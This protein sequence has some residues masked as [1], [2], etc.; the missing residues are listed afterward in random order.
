MSVPSHSLGITRYQLFC[1]LAASLS[2]LNYGWNYGVVN[3]PGDII[4]KCDAGPQYFTNKFPSCMPTSDTIWGL[5][6]G[7]FP[8]GALLGAISCTHFANAYGRRAVLIYSNIIS[9]VAAAILG[10]ALNIPMLITARFL[11]GIAQ[12]CANGTYSNYVAEITTP[13]ARNTLGTVI[14]LS[15]CMGTMLSQLVSLGLV[16][17][18]LWRVLFATTGMIS[19]VSI[20]LLTKCVE[21]PKWLISKQRIYEAQNNLQ[22]LR[23][24]A[25]C[26]VEFA[27]LV[28]TVHAEMGP[29][30]YTATVPDLLRGRTPNNLRHQLLLAVL[31]MSFQQLSGIGGVSFY[32]T[33]LF[34]SIASAPSA[35]YTSKPQLAQILTAVVSTVG[36]VA[37]LVGAIMAGY[38]G[39]RSLL[40]FSHGAMAVSSLLIAVGSVKGYNLLAITMVFIFYCV[41]IVGAGSL[42]WIFPGEMTPIYAVSA[43]VAVSGSIAY[44]CVFVV[45]IVFPLLMNAWNGY[46][47]LLFAAINF[48]ATVLFFFLLPETKDKQVSEMIRIHSVGIHNVMKRK[49]RQEN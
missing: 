24:S 30:S 26:T 27:T 10:T 39:R 35:E 15:I 2:S 37:A 21:S 46:T 1:V 28:E 36:T 14:Q 4:T 40:L 6:I 12:G 49:Y 22:R 38:F 19:I 20:W 13:R 11:V 18:P 48:I 44:A 5:V 23:K 31:G 16:K 7:A 47:F 45:G 43:I 41:Y 32:S 8:L 9:I 3:L 34:T 33:R 25:D 17:P 42:P 29:H